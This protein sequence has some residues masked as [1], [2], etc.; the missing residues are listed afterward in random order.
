MP[1]RTGQ[2]FSDAW[3]EMLRA[4][5][6][7]RLPDLVHPDCVHEYPQSGERIVGQANIRAVFEHYPGGLGRQYRDSLKVTGESPRWAMAPNFTLVRTSGGAGS[8][9]YAMK[10]QYPDGSEWYVISMFELA[11]GRQKHAS[12]FFA[13]LFEAPEWRK[14]YVEAMTRT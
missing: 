4:Q 8:Y 13:R 1:E 3:I 6:Y 11:E 12:F 14:P 7:D 2:E 9:S 5:D 10:A